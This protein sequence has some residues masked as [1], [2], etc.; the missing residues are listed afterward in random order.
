M[1]P[2]IEADPSIP[3]ERALLVEDEPNL[4]VAL[5]IALRKLGIE[6]KHAATLEAA[7][8][9]FETVDPDFILLDRTLPDGDGVELCESVRANG[10]QGAI[11]ML[12]A[13]SQVEERVAGLNSGADDYLSKPFS[14]TELEAR[15]RALGRRRTAAAPVAAQSPV[16]ASA[17]AAAESSEAPS[18]WTRTP[19]RLRVFGP[20]GWV[21]LTPLEFKLADRLI[22]AGGSIVSRDELLKDVW[23]FTLLPKTRTV[24]HFLG[25][26]RKHFEQNPEEPAHF[27]TVRGA[28]Y[29]FEA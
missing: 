27:L 4:A 9:L 26:L 13:R 29:R 16:S 7:Y 24:D 10:Y 5:R 3:F 21:E 22:S 2:K 19:E 8:E 23:G 11:L 15:V 1:T 14:W 12:T 20:K 25:R 17:S 18:L 28:G 6:A